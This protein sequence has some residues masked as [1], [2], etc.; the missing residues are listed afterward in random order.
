MH[1]GHVDVRYSFK[2][3]VLSFTVLKDVTECVGAEAKSDSEDQV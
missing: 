2:N 3:S 1:E